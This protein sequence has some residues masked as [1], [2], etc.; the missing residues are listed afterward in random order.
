MSAEIKPKKHHGLAALKPR[1]TRRD[2][3]LSKAYSRFVFL[4]RRVLPVL[5]VLALAVLVI[6]PYF[7][8]D[9][10]SIEMQANVPNLMVSN[11]HLTGIDNQGRPYS[12]TADRA[13]Q[14][15]GAKNLID[16]EQ[17]RGEI[18]DKNKAL[19]SVQAQKGRVDQSAKKL[20][21]SG[22][23]Q[24]FHDTGYQAAADALEVNL[25][26]GEVE[27]DQPVVLQG[28]FGT[29]RGAGVKI[30]DSGKQVI[31]E[32]PAKADLVLHGGP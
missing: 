9:K 4:L 24:V 16:L 1:D 3:V 5:V 32:G 11:L 27:T 18:T 31:M 25:Q 23:V 7:S 29:L 28:D 8:G 10:V 26:T 30:L 19:I 17:P 13:L 2:R 22:D 21:L 14:A 12:V 20:W 6:W 15:L